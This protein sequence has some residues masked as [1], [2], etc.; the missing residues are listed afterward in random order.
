M[1]V[2]AMVCSFALGLKHHLLCRAA[3][4]VGLSHH[5][6][7]SCQ[8]FEEIMVMFLPDPIWWRA[9]LTPSVQSGSIASGN[10]HTAKPPPLLC[11]EQNF[12]SKSCYLHCV[13]MSPG[14][15]MAGWMIQWKDKK[16]I[17]GWGEGREWENNL[18]GIWYR[19]LTQYMHK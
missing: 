7:S 2:N 15:E 19:P 6:K 13:G 4:P 16:R 17:K 14:A 9:E 11:N 18:T 5:L 3:A 1:C 12:T 8:T 10:S